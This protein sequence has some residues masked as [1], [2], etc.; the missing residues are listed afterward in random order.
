MAASRIVSRNARII[1]TNAAEIAVTSKSRK[2]GRKRVSVTTSP[3]IA[4]SEDV[5]T[6]V[7]HVIARQPPLHRHRSERTHHQHVCRGLRR[8]N[9]AL[10]RHEAAREPGA[11][12]RAALDGLTCDERLQDSAD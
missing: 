9:R 3:W 12:C 6:P 1:A 8:H 11:D 4:D 5:A 2:A 7:E 10:R